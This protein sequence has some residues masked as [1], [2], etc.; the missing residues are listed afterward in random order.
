M[1]QIIGC[2]KL[3]LV[4]MHEPCVPIMQL[5]RFSYL[6][7]DGRTKETSCEI[8]G[9]RGKPR[10]TKHLCKMKPEVHQQCPGLCRIKG[11]CKCFNNPYPFNVRDDQGNKKRNLCSDM[12]SF[13]KEE[14]N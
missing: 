14:R 3:Q 6:K 10:M 7:N 9:K 2:T 8:L 4:A 5:F 12:E 1:N 13:R 11:A